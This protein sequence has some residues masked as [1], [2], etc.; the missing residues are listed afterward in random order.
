MAI[1]AWWIPTYF[2]YHVLLASLADQKLATT[3]RHPTKT[4]FLT[5][6]VLVSW[7]NFLC[8]GVSVYMYTLNFAY[9]HDPGP[10]QLFLQFLVCVGLA[11]WWFY[12]THRFLH[13]P[14]LFS[15]LHHIHHRWVEPISHVSY[16]CHPLENLLSNTGSVLVPLYIMN[17]STLLIHL[18]IFASIT[19]STLAHAGPMKICG[20]HITSKHDAHHRIHNVEFGI[21]LF[22]D[23]L[24]GTRQ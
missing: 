20:V 23:R 12:T 3:Q 13:T 7:G 17:A 6:S 10:A 18:W 21:N 22:M 4:Y 2:V 5:D 11:D 14:W 1:S 15:R 9:E 16:Y 24:L 19:Q 8:T